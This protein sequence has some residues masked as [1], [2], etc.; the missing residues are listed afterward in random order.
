[1]FLFNP[2]SRSFTL[3][4]V[5]VVVAIIAVLVSILLPALKKARESAYAVKCM[6]ML[7]QD[8]IAMLMYAQDNSDVFC[9]Y[10]ETPEQYSKGIWFRW[11]HCMYGGNYLPQVP[12]DPY[13]YCP[14]GLAQGGSGRYAM[15]EDTSN[16]HISKIP[17]P[18]KGVLLCDGVS[19]DAFVGVWS[20]YVTR[21]FGSDR[22][23]GG[24]H[25]AFCDG[26]VGWREGCMPTRDPGVNPWTLVAPN[27]S[28]AVWVGYQLYPWTGF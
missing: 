3:I 14:D 17:S 21:I 18:D 20:P 6:A 24:I 8:G 2:K 13:T 4:E 10:G 27:E 5:L 25:I 12:G 23:H 16:M 28:L 9:R 22:H 26:G 11:Y 15:T 1:M 19:H 7:K